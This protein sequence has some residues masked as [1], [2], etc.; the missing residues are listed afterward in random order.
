MQ[1]MYWVMKYF[2]WT[3]AKQVSGEQRTTSCVV[4]FEKVGQLA[5]ILRF[6]PSSYIQPCIDV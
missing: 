3:M 2:T 5:N 4:M 1:V 6:P